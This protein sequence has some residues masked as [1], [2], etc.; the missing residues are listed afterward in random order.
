MHAW[1]WLVASLVEGRPDSPVRVVIYEDLQCPDCAAFRV[2]MDQNLLPKYR[3]KVAFV[4]RDFP[5]ARHSWAR[6]G[7]I[8]ARH[9]EEI[10]AEYGVAFRRHI[11]AS[12]KETT[13]E[14]LPGRVATFARQNATDAVKARA[15]LEDARLAA[16]VEKDFQDGVARG[17]SRTPTVF[18]NGKPFIET[19]SVEEISKAID[20]ALAQAAP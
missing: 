15:A 6:K 14:N 3:S 11:L 20:D 16:L 9:F 4:H 8:A 18:V 7:A 5:L 17:V 2:M 1:L 19:F 13:S 10:G 12:I